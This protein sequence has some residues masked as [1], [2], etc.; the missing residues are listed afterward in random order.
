MISHFFFFSLLGN[1]GS[2]SASFDSSG[3]LNGVDGCGLRV[4][5]VDG[6]P[7]GLFLFSCTPIPDGTELRLLVIDPPT[8]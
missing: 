4:L 5:S 8:P 6:F 2:W 1:S 7:D 3:Q